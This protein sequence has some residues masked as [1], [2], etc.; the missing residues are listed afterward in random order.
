MHRGIAK[1]IILA[2]LIVP[3]T[4]SPA[5]TPAAAQETTLPPE[6]QDRAKALFLQLRCVV[7][8]NQSIGDSDADVA[9]DLREIVREQMLA[10]KTDREIQ[11]FLV[12][13]YG[14]FILLKPVFAWHTAILWVAPVLL[15]L[16]GAFL[17]WRVT[18]RPVKPSNNEKLSA[19]DQKE[20]DEILRKNQG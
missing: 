9:R 14:E 10:G 12:A 20:L 16:V 7:C 5:A 17:A 13:R 1:F 18:S 3:V 8:Q 11:D 6:M 15:L 2:L 4:F 19:D